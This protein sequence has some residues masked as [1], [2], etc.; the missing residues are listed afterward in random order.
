MLKDGDSVDK[1]EMASLLT[2]GELLCMQTVNWET[3]KGVL[4]NHEDAE[5]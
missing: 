2:N 5:S 4:W 3:G 1:H